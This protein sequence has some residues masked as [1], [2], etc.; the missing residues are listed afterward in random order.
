MAFDG[1]NDKEISKIRDPLLMR[2]QFGEIA[3]IKTDPKIQGKMKDR[4][5]AML[6]LGPSI[7]HGRDTYRFLNL[8]TKR[9][10]NTRDI[11]WLQKVYGEWKGL[12]KPSPLGEAAVIPIPTES[13]NSRNL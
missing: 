4:G 11:T 10:I 8:T 7:D 6:H 5:T 3:Y 12:S 13:R 9:V 2:R 1:L